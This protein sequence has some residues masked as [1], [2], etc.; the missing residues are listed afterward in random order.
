MDD[1]CECKQCA[2]REGIRTPKTD[3]E[4]KNLYLTTGWSFWADTEGEHVPLCAE[5]TDRVMA[6][7]RTRLKVR[8]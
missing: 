2:R 6:D 1:F 7:W 4:A 8:D 3:Q 5:C